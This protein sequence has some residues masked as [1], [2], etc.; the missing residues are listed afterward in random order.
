M[1][2]IGW[3][4][5]ATP[6][7]W[8][9]MISTIGISF[10]PFTAWLCSL[11]STRISWRGTG[12]KKSLLERIPSRRPSGPRTGNAN[13]EDIVTSAMAS[14]SGMSACKLVKSDCS[15]FP[16]VTAARARRTVVAVS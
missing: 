8:W 6:I 2:R 5:G 7:R 16:D 15:I 12:F 4:V 9:S 3:W 13:C 1:K 10:A 11:W 14:R